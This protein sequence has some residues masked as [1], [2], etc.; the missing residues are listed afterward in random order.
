MGTRPELV[1]AMCEGNRGPLLAAVD[2]ALGRLG[3]ARGALASTGGLA[4]TV[5]AGHEGGRRWWT[6]E[7]RT[8][9]EI[10]IDLTDPEAFENLRDLGT[11]GGRVLGWMA[12]SLLGRCRL[13]GESSGRRADDGPVRGG[14]WVAAT[15]SV[16]GVGLSSSPSTC[17]GL[18]SAPDFQPTAEVRQFRACEGGLS[19]G[20]MV[21]HSTRRGR[22]FCRCRSLAGFRGAAGS[23][24]AGCHAWVVEERRCGRSAAS[25]A[26]SLAV[27]ARRSATSG[28]CLELAVA[29]SRLASGPR[30]PAYGRGPTV[31]GR[32]RWVVHRPAGCPQ[33]TA[34]APFVSVPVVTLDFGGPRPRY[35]RFATP[36]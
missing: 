13:S 21:V 3:A 9:E 4:A 15:G 12:M 7:A 24:P 11:A 19:T 8:R 14:L 16:T 27:A 18:A 28:S 23:L 22:L 20:R 36:G 10:P 32:A 2:D 33:H 35:R 6:C 30:Y 31:S 1:L 26:R 25:D 34:R 29:V 5:R 17:S